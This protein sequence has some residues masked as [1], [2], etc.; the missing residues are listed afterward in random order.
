MRDFYHNLITQKSWQSLKDLQKNY[1]FILIGD[2]AVFLYTETLKSKDIDLV[3]E[4]GGLERLREEFEV[5]K[6]E[7]LKKY[8]A[9]KEEAEIDIYVPFYSNPG[10]PAEDLR[11]FPVFLKGFKT[12]EKEILAIL[13]QKALMARTNSPKG[14]KDLADLVSLF[15]LDDFDWQKYQKIILEN[16]LGNFL[17]TIRE[18]IRKTRELNE[19]GLNV[20]RFARFK[21]KIL[22]AL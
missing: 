12:V 4:Y 13:K 9:R 20:H 15:S 7:R 6:N 21:K 19:I 18:I 17:V 5:F 11:K 8:E 3:M 14:R 2:W 16:K 1:Q 22:P 10:L